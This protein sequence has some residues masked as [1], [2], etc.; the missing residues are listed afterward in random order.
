[1][2]I[3][4]LE[5][6]IKRKAKSAKSPNLIRNRMFASESGIAV[7]T[8]SKLNK[9]PMYTENVVFNNVWPLLII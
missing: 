2:K 1:M 8:I 9:N 4:R 6:I 7:K 3:K 5:Q